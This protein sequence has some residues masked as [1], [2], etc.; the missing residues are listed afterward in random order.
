MSVLIHLIY[1]PLDAVKIQ[2]E[3]SYVFAKQGSW[4]MKKEQTALVITDLY[5]K[6]NFDFKSNHKE[7]YLKPIESQ[8]KN[9]CLLE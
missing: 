9:S 1:A 4:L 8:N 3:V 6:E 5:K 2:K 7:L